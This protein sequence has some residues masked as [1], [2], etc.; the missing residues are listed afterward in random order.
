MLRGLL[1]VNNFVYNLL[2]KYLANK[3]ILTVLMVPVT[4]TIG[5]LFDQHGIWRTTPSTFHIPTYNEEI[6]NQIPFNAVTPADL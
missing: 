2:L 4:G 1:I 5:T 3:T 6:Y